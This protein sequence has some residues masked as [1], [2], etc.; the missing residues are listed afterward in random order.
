M[1]ILSRRY[2]R[3]AAA[4]KIGGRGG[5]VRMSHYQ[6]VVSGAARGVSVEDGKEMAIAMG[7]AIAGRLTSC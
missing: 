7:A 3:C 6:I 5:R 2:A 1:K 4:A